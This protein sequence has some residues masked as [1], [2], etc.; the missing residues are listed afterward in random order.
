VGADYRADLGIACCHNCIILTTENRELSA[1][2]ANCT[3]NEVIKSSHFTPL[4]KN[5]PKR[6]FWA[7]AG[8]FG[9]DGRP[10][11]FLGKAELL[12]TLFPVDT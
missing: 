2:S 3:T 10:T 1:L 5:Q 11:P 4:S 7:S 6:S 12:A 9:Q 8:V